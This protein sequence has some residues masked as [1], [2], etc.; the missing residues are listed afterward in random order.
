MLARLVPAATL[1]AICLTCITTVLLQGVGKETM[2]ANEVHRVARQLLPHRTFVSDDY[3]T[4]ISFAYWSGGSFA[5]LVTRFEPGELPPWFRT[6]KLLT[7]VKLKESRSPLAGGGTTRP[8][9]A[10]S[11]SFNVYDVTVP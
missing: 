4:G 8:V 5:G 9:E 3:L 7:F 10:G 2:L 6:Q 11:Q 1:A